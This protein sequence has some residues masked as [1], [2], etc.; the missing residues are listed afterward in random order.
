MKKKVL[1]LDNG[2][3][4]RKPHLIDAFENNKKIELQT[5]YNFDNKDKF[6]FI[7]KIFLKIR[8]PLDSSNFNKRI[9]Q[10]VYD[11]KPDI[12]VILKGNNIYPSTLK[13][14]KDEFKKT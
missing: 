11:F 5:I 2:F 7:E 8:F 9:I 13:K 6:S 12:I 10:S 4:K 3:K 1:I 14:I